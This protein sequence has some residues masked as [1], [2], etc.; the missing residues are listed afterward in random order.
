MASRRRWSGDER[1]ALLAAHEQSGMSVWAFA[2]ESGVPYTTLLHWKRAETSSAPRLLPVEVDRRG[3]AHVDVIVGDV[4][5]R[6]AAD[7]DEALLV[8]VVTAL[9]AC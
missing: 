9:R 2:R 5:V 6:V 8:R 7:F 1:R 3:D 4:V